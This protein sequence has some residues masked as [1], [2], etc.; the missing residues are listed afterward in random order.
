MKSTFV[1][2]LSEPY[3]VFFPAG[4]LLGIIGVSLWFL[5]G[6]GLISYYPLATHA[7]VQMQ[8]YMA[9]FIIGFVL[10]AF[11]GFSGSRQGTVKEI[12]PIFALLLLVSVFH[13]LQ[14]PLLAYIC[15]AAVMMLCLR[16]IWTRFKH[17]E[18]L[19]F[20]PPLELVWIPAALIYNLVGLSLLI[21]SQLITLP[22]WFERSGKLLIEQGF[23]LSIVI[24]VGGFLGPRL[25]GTFRPPA[26]G[27]NSAKPQEKGAVPRVKI[28]IATATVLM[29]TFFLEAAGYFTTANLIRVLIISAMFILNKSLCLKPVRTDQFVWVVW[30]SFWMVF[31]G[32]WLILFFPVHRITL[33]HIVFIGGYTL[34]IT[35]VGTMVSLSHAGKGERLQQPNPVLTVI[36]A[37]LVLSLI[38][39]LASAFFSESYFTLL[40]VSSSFWMLAAIIWLIWLLPLV[41]SFPDPSDVKKFHEAA[42][43]QVLGKSDP[44]KLRTI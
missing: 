43:K 38:V 13:L 2:L 32:Y 21:A 40:V 36:I 18:Q 15:Y 11:P 29:L 25:M 22:F 20:K 7:A 12:F 27:I 6:L 26:V 17:K 1:R 9:A 39:R 33:L 30:A 28:Y 3:R 10:T 8:G 41:C 4:L 44:G 23:I 5:F 35:G 19:N 37:C 16:F 14:M 42:K 24:G 34:M 31:I